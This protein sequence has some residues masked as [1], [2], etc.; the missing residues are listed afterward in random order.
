[1]RLRHVWFVMKDEVVFKREGVMPP[2]RSSTGGPGPRLADR[3]K[4]CLALFRKSAS[5]LS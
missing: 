2:G 5:H 4:R 3:L 1:M